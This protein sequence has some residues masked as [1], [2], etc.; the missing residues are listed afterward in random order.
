MQKFKDRKSL[1]YEQIVSKI[2][3]VIDA[4]S[5]EIQKNE[6]KQK[7]KNNNVMMNYFLKL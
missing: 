1:D 6:Q 4:R 2:K 3:G 7:T 5:M